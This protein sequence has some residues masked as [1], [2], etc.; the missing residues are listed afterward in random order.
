[1]LENERLLNIHGETIL[2]QD[3]QK[4]GSVDDVYLDEGSDRPQWALVKTGLFGARGT[5]VPLE[6]ASERDGEL[7]VPYS[8]EF[9]DDAP[10]MDPDGHLST[11]EEAELYRYYSLDY[12]TADAE[13]TVGYDTS[14][15]TT[16]TAMTRSEEELRVGKTTNEIGRVRLKKYVV[17][18]N[19]QTTV[20]VQREEV[21][22][23]RE[24]ITEANANQALDGPAISEEEHEVILQGE[25]PVIE[26]QAVPKER[27]RLEKDAVVDEV[28]VSEEVRKEEIR[29]EGDIR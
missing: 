9:V 16:D 23:V 19:V 15:P 3:G 22:V 11:A 12:G 26:K 24:P 2:S 10:S 21:R 8:K 17:T 7:L 25:Q 20:P 4:I 5:F 28:Q 13:G 14:G 29:P 1:M 18:E 27:I 6:N